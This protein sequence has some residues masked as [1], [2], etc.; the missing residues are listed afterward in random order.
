LPFP[1]KEEFSEFLGSFEIFRQSV[2]VLQDLCLYQCRKVHLRSA[3]S[4]WR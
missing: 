2:D 4:I 1:S 3:I